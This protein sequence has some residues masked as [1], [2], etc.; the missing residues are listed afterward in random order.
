MNLKIP[1]V[2]LLL[3]ASLSLASPVWGE[4]YTDRVAAIVNGDV[5]LVSD[6]RKHKRPFI[7]RNFNLD[8]GLAPLNKVPTE[9]EILDE[10]IVMRL[11][12]QDAA[13]KGLKIPDKAVDVTIDA[14][15]KRN[16]LTRGQFVLVLSANGTN[17]VEY[18][19]LMKRHILLG[20]LMSVE[21][22][23]K[24]PLS[25]EERQ[26]YFRRNQ[27]KIDEQYQ[28]LFRSENAPENQ[29]EVHEREI[30]T[31]MTVFVGGKVRLR[32]LVLSIPPG[33]KK[34]VR[35]KV[36]DRATKI[37]VEAQTGADFGKL[38]KKYSEG[39]FATAGGDLGYMK[40][41][42]LKADW[43]QLVRSLQVGHATRPLPGPKGIILLYL[44]D[45]KGRKKKRIPLP[46]E[47]RKHLERQWKEAAERSKRQ[48][49]RREAAQKKRSESREA[50]ND[51]QSNSAKAPKQ[52]KES[53]GLLT[54]A[55]EKEYQK[56]RQK[57]SVI[58]AAKKMKLRM[59]EWMKELKKNS[60]IEIKL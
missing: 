59:K 48:R 58:L 3:L 13:G 10:L 29:Q 18:R 44:Q 54:P 55:Q 50:K 1:K 8:L 11:M 6:I 5:I 45:A 15:R 17:Y 35:K 22:R 36:M 37:Y 47:Y 39:P 28:K 27:D 14:N 30:P 21:V 42:E 41:S 46:K 24:V 20:E 51:R 32:R 38:A 53:L 49:E 56:V 57:I 12:E 33:A 2:F 40:S 31:H 60:I 52:P 9:R 43:Q 23:Q 34:S 7:R 4:V 26:I 19:E 25:E 16:K